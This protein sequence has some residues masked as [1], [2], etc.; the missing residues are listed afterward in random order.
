MGGSRSKSSRLVLEFI[1]LAPAVCVPASPRKRT[2]RVI[3][4][5]FQ[6]YPNPKLVMTVL[7]PPL[8]I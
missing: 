6:W 3:L 8:Q 7:V 4:E 5:P 1:A 2:A